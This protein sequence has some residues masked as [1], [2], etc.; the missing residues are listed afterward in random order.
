MDNKKSVF[1][2]TNDN[3]KPKE[4][5]IDSQLLR[6]DADNQP[7]H[8]PKIAKIVDEKSDGIWDWFSIKIKN[9]IHTN[10]NKFDRAR[11]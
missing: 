10:Y 4:I 8:L 2:H 6:T 5:K 9:N 3:S 11:N 7:I 1:I